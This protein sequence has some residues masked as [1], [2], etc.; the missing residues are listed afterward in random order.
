MIKTCVINIQ[1]IKTTY[2]KTDPKHFTIKFNQYLS[3]KKRIIKFIGAC[4]IS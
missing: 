2:K 3:M 4:F 1:F